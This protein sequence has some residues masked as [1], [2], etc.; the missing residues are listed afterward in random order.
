MVI[1]CDR[2]PSVG[3][4]PHGNHGS[5]TTATDRMTRMTRMGHLDLLPFFV[6]FGF[7]FSALRL[8][9]RFSWRLMA[10]Y[11]VVSI[12]VARCLTCSKVPGPVGYLR[13]SVPWNLLP[14]S[15]R[16]LATLGDPKRM[17]L[18]CSCPMSKNPPGF[19]N[20]GCSTT[21]KKMIVT[22]LAKQHL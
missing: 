20:L 3:Q 13:R 2:I 12:L 16:W 8:G 22:S 4:S 21:D 15:G 10:K 7:G 5:L 17:F 18:G 19:G 6:L 9:P 1:C 11:R 14:Q